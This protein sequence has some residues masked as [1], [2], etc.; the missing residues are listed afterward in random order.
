M[1]NKVSCCTFRSPVS[2]RKSEDNYFETYGNSYQDESLSN[3]QHISEREP[4]G[5]VIVFTFQVTF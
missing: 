3:L 5:R 1:G 2:E 4:E